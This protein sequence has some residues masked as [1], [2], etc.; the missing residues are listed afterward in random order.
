MRRAKRRRTLKHSTQLFSDVIQTNVGRFWRLF[1]PWGHGV[2]YLLFTLP[3]SVFRHVRIHGDEKVYVG[4]AL[5]M[6]RAGHLWQQLQ[7]GEINYI[8]G[9]LHYLLL[10]LGHNLF[11]F[12]MLSTVYMNIILAALAVVALRIAADYM[13]PHVQN[14]GALPAWLFASSGA[15]VMFTYSSQMDSEVT[16]LYAIALSLTILAHKTGNI[17]FYFLLWLCAGLAGTLKSPLHSALIGL[18]VVTYFLLSR[19]LFSGLL[20]NKLRIG[21]LILGILICSAGY[22]IPFLL[23]RENWLDTYMYREQINRARFSDSGFMFL[24]NNF[25]FNLFPWS[26]FSIYGINV[27]VREALKKRIV[28]T[29]SIKIGLAFF[30]P[31]FIFFYG[32]G[33]RATW[34]G[35][36]LLASIWTLIGGV[37]MSREESLVK[38]LS[39][40]VIPWSMIMAAAGIAFHLIF[41]GG[42]PWWTLLNTASIVGLFLASTILLYLSLKRAFSLKFLIA[43]LSAFWIGALSLTLTLGEAETTDIRTLLADK[44]NTLRYSN[45]NKENYNEWGYM[46]YMLGRPTQFGNTF[47]ELFDA[48][49]NGEYLVF[50]TKEELDAFRNWTE[51]TNRSVASLPESTLE[52]WRRWPRNARQMREIWKGNEGIQNFWDRVAR[53]YYIVHFPN[54]SSNVQTQTR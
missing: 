20:G 31:T 48:A 19:E 43:G 12:S 5:E 11:G 22:A 33:Y 7:F 24:L 16:S 45:V 35:L 41:Y 54:S 23:D 18:S 9:P 39:K 28:M 50:M 47:Q 6:F 25:V 1:G 13:F 42:T 14:L 2:L 17:K 32:L 21:S 51:S 27:I 30:L 46:A 49:M 53:Q 10:I 36:P 44:E 34:Y 4:Q 37:L 15:F 40:C 3:F 38:I 29:D 26:L 52:I 8:K